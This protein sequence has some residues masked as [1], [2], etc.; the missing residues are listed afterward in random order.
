MVDGRGW[1]VKVCLHWAHLL[2][3]V[4]SGICN[5]PAV[6]R[7]NSQRRHCHIRYW[8]SMHSMLG[9]KFSSAFGRMFPVDSWMVF[10][11][12][13]SEKIWQRTWKWRPQQWM[14]HKVNLISFFI[15]QNHNVVCSHTKV[16]LDL[17]E[18]F[19]SKLT[20]WHF[21]G[22]STLVWKDSKRLSNR[23]RDDCHLLFTLLSINDEASFSFW[24]K[25]NFGMHMHLQTFEDEGRISTYQVPKTFKSGGRWMWEHKR[26]AEKVLHLPLEIGHGIT[27]KSLHDTAPSYISS[28]LVHVSTKYSTTM[29]Y[30]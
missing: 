30:C 28:S 21:S 11:I 18:F 16:V 20:F 10:E 1:K 8:S 23:G 2:S 29:Q 15:R 27:F 9:W 13:G 5:P 14:D 26:N 22:I 24:G 6:D 4:G 3:P 17:I 12:C 19:P 25:E 7:Q